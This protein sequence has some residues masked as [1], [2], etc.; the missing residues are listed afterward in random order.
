MLVNKVSVFNAVVPKEVL[1]V[2]A[3]QNFKT[4]PMGYDSVSF[5]MAK[6]PKL[7]TYDSLLWEKASCDDEEGFKKAIED[8]GKDTKTLYSALGK[9][10]TAG[11]VNWR[12]SV[13]KT[14]MEII[15][16]KQSKGYLHSV[17]EA[18]STGK[19]K[20][21]KM[22][23]DLLLSVDTKAVLD[24]FDPKKPE[25]KSM[26]ARLM[27]P[28]DPE[29]AL[30]LFD[31]EKPEDNRMLTEVMLLIDPGT[32]QDVNALS[33]YEST[34][35]R[36]AINCE[37][38]SPQLSIQLLDKASKGDNLGYAVREKFIKAKSWLSEQGRA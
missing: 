9:R 29:K 25:E 18:F 11:N 17:I 35:E 19:P 3:A 24:L 5:R 16:K 22:L 36:L 33:R 15:A 31:P 12:R 26:H 10:F 27:F 20:D 37:D 30:D 23:A 14:T 13:Q 1:S 7:V 6:V 28:V 4:K 34:I 8:C 21:K 38:V 2:G 32:I